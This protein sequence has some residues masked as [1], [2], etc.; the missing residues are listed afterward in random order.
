MGC[1]I[2]C[3]INMRMMKFVLRIGP[4]TDFYRAKQSQD[5]LTRNVGI[6]VEYNYD[7][8]M[9]IICLNPSC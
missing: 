2:A 1:N 9:H 3:N 5:I 4:I 8:Q 7:K 6:V